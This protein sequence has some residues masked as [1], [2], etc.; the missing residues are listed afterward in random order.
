MSP[1]IHARGQVED[2]RRQEADQGDHRVEAGVQAG[3][4]RAGRRQRRGGDGQ[5]VSGAEST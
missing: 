2:G 3:A 5:D 1:A 4:D